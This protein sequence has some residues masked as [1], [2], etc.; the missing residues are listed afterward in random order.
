LVK[1]HV[2]KAK[3]PRKV[4]RNHLATVR[5]VT[6]H[7]QVKSDLRKTEAL[8]RRLFETSQE[9]IVILDAETQRIIDANPYM[10][11]LSGYSLEQLV[12]KQ[13]REI[14]SFKD[15]KHHIDFE[16]LR[17]KE[18]VHIEPLLI[19][20]KEKGSINV[21][22]SSVTYKFKD[23]QVI[24]CNIRDITERKQ[25]EKTLQSSEKRYM[26]LAESISDVFFAMDSN[27]KYTYWNKASENLTGISAKDAVGK[28]ILDVFPDTEDTRRAAAIYQEVLKTRQ[29]KSFI[30]E[31]RLGDKNFI[32]EIDTY[33]TRDGISI[34]VKD[35]TERT[36]AE[37]KIK[38]LARYPSENPN[39][40]LRINKDG[41]ILHANPASELLLQSWGCKVGEEAPKYWRDIVAEVFA[42]QSLRNVDV[43]LGEKV[44]LFTVTPIKDASYVNLYGRDI[45]DRK[46]MEEEL[47]RNEE[48]FR[49]LVENTSDWIWEVDANGIYTYS[50]PKVKDL[51]GYD[52]KDIVG[53]TP[54]DF[55]SPEEARRVGAK[56][57]DLTKNVES[58]SG[59]EN[60]NLHKNGRK[61]VLETSAVPI[62]SRS[63]ELLGYRGID[64]NITQRKEAEEVLHLTQFALDH[65]GDEIA[66]IRPDAR[67]VYVN[68]RVCQS[69]GY[70]SSE[71]L[72]MAVYDI[73]PNFSK[74]AWP[75]HWKKVKE[76]G[77]FAFESI[78]RAKD[79]REYPVEITVNHLEFG[80]R[81][82]ICSIA[83]DITERKQMEKELRRYS[84]H[85]ERLV[86]ERTRSLHESEERYRIAADFTYDWE[87]WE[88]PDGSLNYVSPSCERITGYT[89]AEFVNKPILLDDLILPEDKEAWTVHHHES[90]T[91]L[92]QGSIEFRIRRRDGGV[93]WIEHVCNAVY[94]DNH[95]YIGVRSSNRDI[96]Q[97][98][99]IEQELRESEYR[100]RSLF[101]HLGDGI[102][103]ADVETKKF[104]L[105]NRVICQMLGY[106]Q[107]EVEKLGVLD[108]HPKKDLP[109]VI[110]RF[111]KL[112]SQEIGV[113]ENIPVQRKDGSVL[114]ADIAS[115]PF[116]LNGKTCLIGIFRDMTERK[117]MEE[118]L[119]ES[120]QRFRAVFDNAGDGI[121]VADVETK[122]FLLGNRVICQ[123]L[124]YSQEEVKKLGVLD[125]HP[126]KD[127]PYVIE[128]FEK[129]AS[130][131]IEVAENIPVQR[132]D[133]S[134][135]Y[136]D[137]ASSP[138]VLNGKTCLI[139]VFR[140]I[141]ERRR[142]GRMR[143]EFI[144][145]ISH[146]LRTPLG[147]LRIHVEH[148]LAGKLGPVPEKIRSSLQVI[149]LETDRLVELIDAVLDVQRFQSDR[150]ELNLQPLDIRI[151]VGQGV[152]E[153]KVTVEMKQQHLHVEVP[154]KLLPING[155]AVRL[156]QVLTNLLS[157]ASKF[158]PENG[159]ITI[160]VRD[161]AEALKVSV[162]DT[163]I[164][165]RKEDLPMIFQPFA[166][167]KKHTW[168]KG[169]GLGLSVTKGI[170]EAHGGKIW[171][172]SDGEGKGATFTF[173]IP[174]PKGES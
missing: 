165:I 97:R 39:P 45:T 126:K 112:A 108:I 107:E 102:L 13:L 170:I 147:P 65:A 26:E 34:I 125:I 113:A 47:R 155:D 133:G 21:E 18:F 91:Q 122:K 127:L 152:E 8:Y 92:K 27:L 138:F 57:A 29:H 14:E 33:P 36:R 106:S 162:S 144:S 77:S 161:E 111:E 70:S 76:R 88:R 135:L 11:R 156:G 116:V 169:A 64:R 15:V 41:L 149:K 49:S 124:G 23:R 139:G 118:A 94:D 150:F 137:I 142:M 114:Y 54:Y 46:R 100:F 140:D 67:L 109:Y 9:G 130:Q 134:V 66:V 80:D 63:G 60:I 171:A 143:D 42:S 163:G 56:F 43:E 168:M 3:R 48:R 105:G 40:V 157:N 96:T 86:D 81:E 72:S 82:L 110:E 115:S 79:G 55:M 53:K 120:E 119:K 160:N 73:D 69:L 103:V 84:E 166:T 52:P 6:E 136:A 95:K 121:L 31:Y 129:L 10:Q 5:D 30:N 74:A 68:E 128:R 78:H 89:A 38:D 154:D 123:M 2:T 173:T 17:K 83:R 146:E 167:I 1:K 164:G 172:E 32:F 101:D 174:R 158:T 58:F 99:K 12:G 159:Q 98:K 141:T 44:I 148:V 16:E 19:K 93:T 131:E 71:L 35:V 61:V 87:A 28:S 4:S 24:Q 145:A 20:V 85:L 25:M 51:L 50:S 117:R 153:T 22:F 75:A 104:F 62:L 90:I 37:E 132:K 7:K 59:L 151:V